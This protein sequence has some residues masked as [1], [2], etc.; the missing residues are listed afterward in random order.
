MICKNCNNLAPENVEFCPHCGKKL[1]SSIG[2]KRESC[3]KRDIS[4]ERDSGIKRDS[5]FAGGSSSSKGPT[6]K[7]NMGG[8][9]K[10]SKPSRE[11]R[12]EAPDYSDDRTVRVRRAPG[13]ATNVCPSCGTSMPTDSEF[14]SR[15]GC[16]VGR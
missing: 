1:V 7:I 8:S 15:C 6:I 2:F 16:F 4:I 9:K 12:C 10:A 14:C 5:G 13:S 3:L 11:A